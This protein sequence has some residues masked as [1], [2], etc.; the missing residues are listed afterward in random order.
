MPF[1]LKNIS[2]QETPWTILL[3]NDLDFYYFSL[4]RIS[5]DLDL[6]N[7]YWIQKLPSFATKTIWSF[8][9]YT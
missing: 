4:N 2:W 7:S 8:T 6:V 3:D 5:S 9:H 1:L